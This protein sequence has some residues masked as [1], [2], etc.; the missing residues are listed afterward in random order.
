MGR[1]GERCPGELPSKRDEKFPR[2]PISTWAV[3]TGKKPNF[4]REIGLG[5]HFFKGFLISQVKL[6]YFSFEK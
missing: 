2:G 6:V 3:S 4:P 1:V 5:T